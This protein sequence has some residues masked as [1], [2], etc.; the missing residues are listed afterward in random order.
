LVNEVMA[1]QRFPAGDESL[2]ERAIDQTQSTITLG[3]ELLLTTEPQHPDLDGFLAQRVSAIGLRDVFR[4]GYG[5]LDRLRKAAR[6]LHAGSRISLTRPASLLDRPWGP[7]VAALMRWF[8][9]LPLQSTSARTRPL[10]TFA[11]VAHATRGIAEAGALAALAFASDGYAIDPIWMTRVD[12]PERL[13]L[14]D[15]IRTAIVHSHLPGSRTTM[16]PLTGDDLAWAVHNLLA[17]GEL[18][19]VVRRDFSARCDTLGIGEYT[20]ALANTV[21]TRLRIEL[22]GLELV[23]GQPDLT[24]TG[25]FLTVQQ[26]GMWLKTRTGAEMN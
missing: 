21:L 5:A 9:E 24:R 13:V 6:A 20:T 2:Q 19:D 18:V 4:V 26:V 8:P 14:G 1:A 15:L 22:L 10:R 23:D 16:A 17:G 3:L 25:G 7:A 12:E 11:D